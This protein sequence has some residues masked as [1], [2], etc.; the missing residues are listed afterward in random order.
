M[1]ERLE[2]IEKR[3]NEL[4]EELM[5][6]EV[7]S[8]IKK[9]LSLTREQAG[10]REAYDI[11]QVYKKLL[12]DID[13]AN[14]MVKDPDMAEFAR[15]EL[16]KYMNEKKDLESK[17]EVILLPKDPNDGK[18]VIVEIRG[19]AG[20]DEGNIFAGDLYEMYRKLAEKEGW[21]IE[22]LDEERS[23]AGG[24]SLIS[25]MVKGENVYS[26]LKY[27]SGAHRVQR[28]PATET[29]GRVHTS[30]ATVLVMPEAE[31]VD[32]ELEFV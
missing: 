7:V 30:T 9:T 32:Y 5:S 21:K 8:D 29:Q 28:V 23:E 26:K 4:N 31:E 14:E 6:P 19:A 13:A 27:E 25:F 20:G 1:L 17:I 12:D 3:Y 10:L 15:E 11:Y 24:Y 2:N 22:V 18:N 16:E